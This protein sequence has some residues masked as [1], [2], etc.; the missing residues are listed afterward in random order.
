M[1]IYIIN[2]ILE[3]LLKLTELK[4]FLN[5]LKNKEPLLI[6]EIDSF[7]K[8]ELLLQQYHDI[9]FRY[10]QL[11]IE[12][13]H[14]SRRSFF[15]HFDSDKTPT[16]DP[17][18]KTLAKR[19]SHDFISPSSPKMNNL[20]LNLISLLKSSHCERKRSSS[21]NLSQKKKIK[22]PKNKK[23]EQN[24]LGILTN[25]SPLCIEEHL[26]Q[27]GND[28]IWASQL[29][30]RKKMVK[31]ILKF[32]ATANNYNKPIVENNGKSRNQRS[33]YGFSKE[34]NE[35]LEDEEDFLVTNLLN[36]QTGYFSDTCLEMS[37]SRVIKD[38]NVS[39]NDF[40]Y[41]RLINKGAFGRVWLVKRKFTKDIYAMK[42]V[43]L[44]MHIRNKK[45]MKT[46][47]AESLIYDILSSDFVVKALFK[48][49]YETFL[50]FVTEYMIGGDLG[51][52]LHQYQAL[53]ENI[54]KFYM[55]ELIL[56]IDHL[57]SLNIIHKDLK[58]DNILLDST[59]H[60]KLTDF[61]LSEMG[62]ALITDITKISPK[63]NIPAINLQLKPHIEF[64]EVKT[65]IKKESLV[66]KQSYNKI[67]NPLKRTLGTSLQKRNHIIGTPDYIAPEILSGKG[68]NSPSVDW[69]ALG[70]MFFEFIVGIPPFNS[71]TIEETFE[72][73][74]G[75]KIPWESIPIG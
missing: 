51:Y 59:G 14:F 6:Q 55:A 32:K 56:A 49:T 69:W 2:K 27:E 50:C 13:P 38:N 37:S 33:F 70:V 1:I 52:L 36:T 42:I 75:L 64:I 23:K 35:M 58:P 30:V 8:Y 19:M 9:G 4:N 67:L 31:K 47:K 24:Q 26:L 3:T 71:E 25:K 74:R 46:L 61:G 18:T 43:D 60:I 28:P 41:L 63:I 53:D 15:V 40:E 11:I 20:R 65:I 66:E 39:V 44:T 62:V 5:N 73:I 48:F 16:S 68:G 45:D 17:I 72:N 22:E 34:L 29:N 12:V 57:H 7:S 54:A 21:V 10:L